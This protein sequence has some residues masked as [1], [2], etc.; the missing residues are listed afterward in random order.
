MARPDKCARRGSNAKVAN[1]QYRIY[2]KRINSEGS[3]SHTSASRGVHGGEEEAA[4]GVMGEGVGVCNDHSS[5][6]AGE[7]K[8]DLSI[9]SELCNIS[10]EGHDRQVLSD[11]HSFRCLK[12]NWEAWV[13]RVGDSEAEFLSG[14]VT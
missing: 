3:C 10:D 12:E 11:V 6:Q 8:E 4:A 5:L 13:P 2:S 9:V 14:S 1:K 7:A